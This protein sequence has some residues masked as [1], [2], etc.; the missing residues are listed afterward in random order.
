M[1]ECENGQNEV[2]PYSR[3]EIQERA[4][5]FGALLAL[6]IRGYT[7]H[8]IA[9]ELGTEPDSVASQLRRLR[10]TLQNSDEDFEIIWYDLRLPGRFD[11]QPTAKGA[12]LVRQ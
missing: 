7:H 12:E 5:F 2:Y 1:K 8:A 6:D 10:Y 4:E 11:W 3:S 9:E